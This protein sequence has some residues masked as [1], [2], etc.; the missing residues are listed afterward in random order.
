MTYTVK[1]L[2]AKITG[3]NARSKK[4]N[5]DLD[6]A[7]AACVSLLVEQDQPCVNQA[8]RLVALVN[9]PTKPKLVAYLR[10]RIPY[11]FHKENGFTKKDKS[12]VAKCKEQFASDFTTFSEFLNAEKATTEKTAIDYFARV[13]KNVDSMLKQC[14]SPIAQAI[15]IDAL[16]EML[17]EKRNELL[18]EVV[19]DTQQAA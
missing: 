7:I 5:K 11:K 17:N 15:E 6:D 18:K 2:S 9:A 13:Q 1:A 4:F 3:L 8:N 19:T 14:E 16:L 12:K 10:E